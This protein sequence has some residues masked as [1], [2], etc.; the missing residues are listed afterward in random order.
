VVETDSFG[1][2]LALR[3][4]TQ[5]FGPRLVG[6][7]PGVTFVDNDSG[8]DIGEADVLLLLADGNMVSVEVKRRA[9]GADDRAVQLMNILAVAINAPY[10]ILAVTQPARDCPQLEKLRHDLPDRPRF[11]L[12]D[13]Q[14][15]E[16]LVRWPVGTDPFAW[17]PRA[18][19]DDKERQSEFTKSLVRYDLDTSRDFV[20]SRLLERDLT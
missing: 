12:T 5:L 3:W 11:L 10:D 1:H 18:I 7:Y 19:D 4:L 16:N 13:D 6:A 17:N 8:Q 9:A 2:M 20:S 15:H 14:L